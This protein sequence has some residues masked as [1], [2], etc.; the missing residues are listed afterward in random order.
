MFQPLHSS[1]ENVVLP[2]SHLDAS[3]CPTLS[4]G[5]PAYETWSYDL[6][7]KALGKIG[8]RAWAPPLPR[9]YSKFGLCFKLELQKAVSWDHFSSWNCLCIS[10]VVLRCSHM[11]ITSLFC[12]LNCRGGQYLACHQMP[13]TNFHT[14]SYFHNLMPRRRNKETKLCFC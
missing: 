9:L 10:Q 6:E 3:P 1:G 7:E 2:S 14:S 12:S 5:P 13:Y 4:L 11:K 8:W